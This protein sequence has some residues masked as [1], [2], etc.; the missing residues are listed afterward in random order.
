M[1]MSLVFLTVLLGMSALVVDVGSWYRAHRAAQSTADASALAGAQ[2]LPDTAQATALAN[3]YA[4]K[5]SGSTGSPG[6]NLQV[7]FTQ[8]DYETDTI[9][10]TYTKPHPGFFAKLF[11]LNS[12]DVTGRATARAWNVEVVHSGVAPITVNYKHPDLRCTRSARP[13]CNPDFGR[14]T[15]LTLED[16]HSPHSKDAAGAFGLINLNQDDDGN[17]GADVLADWLLNGYPNDLE[18]GNYNSAPSANFNNNQFTSALDQQIG[19]ELLFPVYRILRGPGAN[20][21]Y[22]IIG[23]VGFVITSY[24]TSGSDGTIYGH[25]SRMLADGVPAEHG[26]GGAEGLGVHKIELTH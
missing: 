7:T 11:G 6:S 12:V 22:E 1:V 25:F 24:N 26:G 10:V 16:I 5:N 3:E 20:A 13:T 17:I 9:H 14:A 21:V 23:W 8:Q 4:T 19:N 15:T 18:T 2:G